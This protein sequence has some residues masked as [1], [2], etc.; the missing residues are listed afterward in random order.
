[1]SLVLAGV[2]AM[3]K[4]INN[5][6]KPAEYKRI[7]IESSKEV[8][9]DGYLVKHVVDAPAAIKSLADLY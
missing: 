2:V 9:Y 6:L 7:L 5:E 4:E 1:M 3:M 8:K